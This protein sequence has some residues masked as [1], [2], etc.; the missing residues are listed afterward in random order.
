MPSSVSAAE[1]EDRDQDDVEGLWIVIEDPDAE[2]QR[3][4]DGADRQDDEAWRERKQQRFH[5][6]PQAN[7]ADLIVVLLVGRADLMV[8]QSP[9][10][11]P[12]HRSW[13]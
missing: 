1:D 5:G 2:Q 10:R 11:Y 13:I 9:A 3:G 8:G 4:D 7:S 6:I 12:A